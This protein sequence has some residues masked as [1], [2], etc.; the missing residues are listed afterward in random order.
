MD[1]YSTASRTHGEELVAR[2]EHETRADDGRIR[3]LLKHGLLTQRLRARVRDR[4]ARVRAD[5]AD[6]HELRAGLARGARDVLRAAPL[7][8]LEVVRGAVHDADEGDDHGRAFE[9]GLQG[10]RL[11]DVGRDGRE[12]ARRGQRGVVRELLV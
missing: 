7:H 9:G 11:C 1:A 12:E 4:R 6:V 2:P 8:A 10:G 3:A 5:G